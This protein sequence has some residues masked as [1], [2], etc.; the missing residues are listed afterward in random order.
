MKY[1]AVCWLVC[2]FWTVS[3][4]ADLSAIRFDRL[5]PLGASA[6]TSIEVEI[7]GNDIEELSGLVFDQPGLSAEAIPERERWFRIDV[8][9]D[10]PVG[11]Y[12]V[13][14]SG[15]FGISNPRLFA[16]TRGLLDVADNGDNRSSDSAQ[17]IDLNSAINGV[18]D[19]NAEDFYRI[20]A[21]AGQRVTID[22]QAQRLDSQ[23]NGVMTLTTLEGR[24]LATSS[25]YYGQDP[26]IDFLVPADGEYLLRVNDLSYRGGQP[27][28]LVVSD[29]PQVENIFPAAIQAGTTVEMAALGRNFSSLGGT[30]SIQSEGDLPLDQWTFSFTAPSDVLPLGEYRF[31]DHP[32][33]H[34][35]LPTAATCTLTGIQVDPPG[36]DTLWSFPPV[37]MTPHPVQVEQEPNNEASAAQHVDMP[38]VIAGRFDDLQDADWFELQVPENGNYAFNVYCERIAGRADAYVA[39]LDADGN[40]INE[41]DDYGH[42]INAFDGHLRDPSQEISLQADRTYR[43]LVQ[44]RYR[45][46][47]PRYHYVLEVVPAEA[48][49]HAAVIHRSNPNPAGTTI[50][51]GAATY[52][53]VVIHYLGNARGE[54]S[55]TAEN[56]PPGLHVAPTTINNDTRGT[57]VLWADADA[58]DWTGQLRL[59]ATL[60]HEG[61]TVQRLVRPYSRVANNDGTSQ[62]T[63][64]LLVAIREQAPFD[65]TYRAGRTRSCRRSIRGTELTDQ[66]HVERRNKYHHDTAAR[67][68]GRLST[69]KLRH[70]GRPGI[71]VPMTIMVQPNTRPGR[72]TLTVLG[73]SQVPFNKDAAATERP[74][75]LVA[76]PARPVT[77]TV[78]P[79]TE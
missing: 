19:G 42:R 54:I 59:L 46:G 49:F 9:A 13:Y 5:Q 34:S 78:L 1:V 45:R 70:H 69:G 65:L 28:R 4:F 73:Q 14:L 53:D 17:S 36:I 57:L 33:H 29:H 47:G 35:V 12:D 21:E 55:I 43:V 30:T 25:D 76:T 50:Y 40:R 62:V 79:A 48:D 32:T 68:P 38:L 58:P 26:F 61:R 41:F 20:V 6:G 18:A 22:C 74:P 71:M 72:Y 15:R 2:E 56:L 64:T 66:P 10:V 31:R 7:L 63:R 60:E 77:I 44:D 24:I 39:I 27:Y 16:V 11:T 8:A 51:K 75:T 52:M 37:L 23:L 67:I 3:L